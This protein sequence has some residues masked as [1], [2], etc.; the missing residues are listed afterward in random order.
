MVRFS[1]FLAVRVS[2][3]RIDKILKYNHEVDCNPRNLCTNLISKRIDTMNL[4]GYRLCHRFLLSLRC[5][6][7]KV[8]DEE[9]KR[10]ADVIAD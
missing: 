5:L 6:D 3:F 7:D 8:I 4:T 1:E 9:I 2:R 10:L